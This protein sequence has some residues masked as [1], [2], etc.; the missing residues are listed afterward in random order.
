[1]K[2]D[3]SRFRDTFFQEAAEHVTR[4]SKSWAQPPTLTPPAKK[5][6]A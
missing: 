1:M 6:F 5:S 4:R 3:L 2:I